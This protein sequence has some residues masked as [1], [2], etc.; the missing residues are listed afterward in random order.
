MAVTRPS[1]STTWGT[2][3]GPFAEAVQKV[4]EPTIELDSFAMPFTRFMWM[5]KKYTAAYEL[6]DGTGYGFKINVKYGGQDMHYADAPGT[7]IFTPQPKRTRFGMTAKPVITYA[8]DG[9]N[10]FDRTVYGN[11]DNLVN[12]M[13]EKAYDCNRGMTKSLNHELFAVTGTEG[14]VAG[15]DL[16]LDTQVTIDQTEIF[17]KNLPDIPGRLTSIAMAIRP[18]VTGHNFQGMNSS[19]ILWRPYVLDGAGTEFDSTYTAWCVTTGDNIDLVNAPSTA[20]NAITLTVLSQLLAKMQR[21]GYLDL[22]VMMPTDLYRSVTMQLFGQSRGS[23]DS[24]LRDIGV[25][26]SIRYPEYNATLFADPMMDALHPYSVFAFDVD[27]LYWACVSNMDG[28]DSWGPK[29]YPWVQIPG[30]TGNVFSKVLWSN[31]ICVN[32]RSTG[33]IHGLIP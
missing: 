7:I 32:R 13:S 9:I 2:W 3:S 17:I 33:A 26:A 21:G 20:T 18:H 8:M 1:F 30:T 27:S 14:V 28:S 25:E 4:I 29:L 6:E 23:Q 10:D 24:P 19:N 16:E 15:G 11:E 12:W 5:N 22:A 31:I